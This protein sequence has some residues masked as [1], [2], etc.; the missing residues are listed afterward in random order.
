MANNNQDDNEEI[1]DMYSYKNDGDSIIQNSRKAAEQMAKTKRAISKAAAKTGGKVAKRAISKFLLAALPYIAAV[2]AFIAIIVLIISFLA[3]LFSGP[4]MLRGQI[5]QMADEYWTAAK[6][7]LVGVFEGDDYAEATEEHITDVGKYIEYMGYSLEGWGFIDSSNGDKVERDDK[8]NIKSVKSTP[9]TEYLAAENRTYMLSTV[10]V[11]SL[12]RYLA[13]KIETGNPPTTVN[14]TTVPT[15]GETQN[16][17]TQNVPTTAQNSDYRTG[18]LNISAKVSHVK[19]E[20][21]GKT[22]YDDSNNIAVNGVDKITPEID[23]AGK[24]LILKIN[25]NRIVDGQKKEFETTCIYNLDGWV[26][27]YGKPIEFLLALHLGTMAPD[28]AKTVAMGKD[29]DTRVNIKIHKSVQVVKLTFRGKDLKELSNDFEKMYK[30]KLKDYRDANERAR[31][32]QAASR[33]GAYMPV[34]LPHPNPEQEAERYTEMQLGYTREELKKAEK[35]EKEETKEKYTPYI[36]R[37]KN[38]W[39]RDLV[40]KE[41]LET[42]SDKDA[43][44]QAKP[45][46]KSGG[47]YLSKFQIDMYTSG[48]IYQVK[49]PRRG[50]VNEKLEDLV[51]NKT[52]TKITGLEGKT[53]VGKIEFKDEMANAVVMLDK[54]AQKSDDAKYIVRDLK[55]WL[56]IHE[57]KFVDSHILS[58]EEEKEVEINKDDAKSPE[59]EEEEFNINLN[60][61]VPKTN[62]DTNV[63]DNAEIVIKAMQYLMKKGFTVEAAAGVCGNITA[64][65]SWNPNADNGSHYGIFQ[66]D[67]TGDPLGQPGGDRWP[68]ILRWLRAQ[69]QPVGDVMNQLVAAFNS[70]DYYSEKAMGSID[71][72]KNITDVKEAAKMWAVKWERC[73]DPDG[74][75]QG[76]QRRQE[77]A[78]DAYNKYQQYL[79]NK[80]NNSNSNNTTTAT[81]KITTT[82]ENNAISKTLG[83]EKTAEIVYKG[84]R[85]TVKTAEME[86]D[87]DVNSILTGTVEKVSDDTIQIKGN[88]NNYAGITVIIT[89]ANINTDLKVGDR[90]L[91][92]Q[93]IA[94]TVSGQDVR[95]QIQ[96]A[97]RKAVSL[98]KVLNM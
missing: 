17:T 95:I 82:N 89:G 13:G 54:A 74:T 1:S 41:Y 97:D 67:Y 31:A 36:V 10:S 16:S 25:Q 33:Y 6:K 83:G 70:D 87:I 73:V 66:W 69:G 56:A 26:G 79:A 75:I 27:R 11:S 30:E 85:A 86:N 37:V 62:P 15:T 84:S 21:D 61:T 98:E 32:S 78:V 2:V 77:G 34:T 58:F 71:A 64:E 50:S 24:K 65:S 47:L 63:D 12:Y 43:Y 28:F 68:K 45:T 20:I 35:Y 23:R 94:K 39:Y 93:Q 18:M 60:T 14:N 9:I 55:E 96:D 7:W 72:V 19:L 88:T 5:V 51:N 4:D 80:N 59:S 76:L 92:N 29:F 81:A 40:F 52:W 22:V 38:H 46:K 42:A 48:D 57:F 91:E 90:I 44:V 49:E 53:E 3:F 8:K